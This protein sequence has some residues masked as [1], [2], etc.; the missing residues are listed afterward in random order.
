MDLT[1]RSRTIAVD[2]L[3][4]LGSSEGRQSMDSITLDGALMGAIFTD[5]Y[6]PSG[7]L[8]AKVTATGRYTQYV[9]AGAGGVGV[10][11]GVLAEG[12]ELNR[13][14]LGDT[15]ATFH[16]V[17]A[18]LQWRGEIVTANLPASSGFVSAANCAADAAPGTSF[19]FV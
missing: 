9:T 18:S 15:A 3:H 13:Q 12:V 2:N 5:G 17:G 6:V 11:V 7:V 1:E 16:N 8:L 19:R 4:W 10:F 14:E